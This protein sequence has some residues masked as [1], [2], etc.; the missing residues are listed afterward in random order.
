MR[1]LAKRE[2]S[3]LGDACPPL[4]IS[5]ISADCVTFDIHTLAFKERKRERKGGKERER[6][7][8]REREGE[9]APLLGQ[10]NNT[11]V[12]HGLR[13]RESGINTK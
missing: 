13:A 3:A 4:Y 6:E 5:R 10:L 7:R 11:K 2:C 9:M 1:S 12:L 8:E